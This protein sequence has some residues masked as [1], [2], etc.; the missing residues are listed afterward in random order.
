MMMQHHQHNNDDDGDAEEEQKKQHENG[1]GGES[2]WGQALRLLMLTNNSTP[3][4]ED[5]GDDVEGNVNDD[6]Q[7]DY[8][9]SKANSTLEIPTPESK[10]ITL[11]DYGFKPNNDNINRKALKQHQHQFVS[12]GQKRARKRDATPMKQL[13]LDLVLGLPD[14][15]TRV[16]KVSRARRLISR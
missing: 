10:Q 13:T 15:Q 6:D 14:E 3:P 11:L 8:R 9:L 12:R 4:K 7:D 2:E 5:D 16:R 1:N